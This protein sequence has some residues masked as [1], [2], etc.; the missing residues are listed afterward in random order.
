[1][2]VK[3]KVLFQFILTLKPNGN[4]WSQ[5]K[6]CQTDCSHD[7]VVNKVVDFPIE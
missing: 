4:K 3:I 1:M 5:A 7:F 6:L 2:Y